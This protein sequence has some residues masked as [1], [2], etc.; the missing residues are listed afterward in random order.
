MSRSHRFGDMSDF[1][2]RGEGCTPPCQTLPGCRGEFSAGSG[3]YFNMEKQSVKFLIDV[4]L[5]I[6]AISQA[7]GASVV[8]FQPGILFPTLLGGRRPDV[9]SY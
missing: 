4:I 7:L 2:L 9:F 3:C 8:S 5:G 1:T 6:D